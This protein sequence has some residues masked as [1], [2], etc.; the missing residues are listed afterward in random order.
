MQPCHVRRASSPDGSPAVEARVPR[1]LHG[2]LVSHA[3]LAT[4]DRQTD[5]DAGRVASRRVRRWPSA[6]GTSV[7][8]RRIAP[9]RMPGNSKGVTSSELEW[10][11]MFSRES[12]CLLRGSSAGT[13]ALRHGEVPMAGLVNQDAAVEVPD[14]LKKPA[15]YIGWQAGIAARRVDVASTK[16]RSAAQG[17]RR[18]PP[19][20]GEATPRR[21]MPRKRGVPWRGSRS[22]DSLAV[23]TMIRFGTSGWRGIVARSSRSATCVSSSRHDHRPEPA[24]PVW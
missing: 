13:A 2:H 8:M 3:H 4:D 15:V 12:P 1:T 11:A 6:G 23:G 14:T 22:C 9:W 19:Q 5:A 18:R 24:R 21:C 7:S 20:A 16:A 17:G 10:L